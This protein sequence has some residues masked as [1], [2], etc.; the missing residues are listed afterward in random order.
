MLNREKMIERLIAD[1]I[2]TIE[3]GLQNGDTEYLYYI[4]LKGKGYENMTLREVIDEYNTRTW[5]EE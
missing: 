5:E 4:L 1:D 3:Y 2:D